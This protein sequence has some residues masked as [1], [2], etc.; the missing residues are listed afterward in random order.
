MP[1]RI[2]KTVTLKAPL[3]RVWRAVSDYQEFGR[4]FHVSLDSPFV[5]GAAV[6]GRITYPGYEHLTMTLWVET[7]EAPLLFAFRWHPYAVDPAVDYS[8]EPTTRVEFRLEQVEG[9]TR[10]IVTESGFDAL[11]DHRR[12]EAFMRNEGGWEAQF[13]NVRR[14]VEG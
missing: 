6:R 7:M 13:D 8:R 1:D 10:L 12:A 5:P 9:S 2:E 14:Y 3:E 11:P 4:W